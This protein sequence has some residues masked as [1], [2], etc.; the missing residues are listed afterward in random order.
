[1][2]FRARTG[3]TTTIHRVFHTTRLSEFQAA[4]TRLRNSLDCLNCRPHA[5]LSPTTQPLILLPG[6]GPNRLQLIQLPR[7][8]LQNADYRCSRRVSV[9]PPA[10][11]SEG[12]QNLSRSTLGLDVHPGRHPFE[13]QIPTTPLR[14]APQNPSLAHGR[15]S[16]SLKSA[17]FF[18][19]VCATGRRPGSFK[20]CSSPRSSNPPA[21]LCS[22]PH[23]TPSPSPSPPSLRH[24]TCPSSR[25]RPTPVTHAEPVQPA[26]P[27]VKAS[28]TLDQPKPSR[29]P[30]PARQAPNL[31]NSTSQGIL[32]LS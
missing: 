28:P 11:N 8:Q 22:S 14:Q 23:A 31:C 17:Q 3:L 27:P 30:A 18:V 29:R 6:Q 1:M 32:A 25:P 15:V 4:L 26:L 19:R 24:P 10:P 2:T 7:T 21:S 12:D 13:T 16:P 9:T 20:T 5:D